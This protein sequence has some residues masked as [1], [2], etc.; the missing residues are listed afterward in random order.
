MSLRVSFTGADCIDPA[1]AVHHKPSPVSSLELIPFA[2][3]GVESFNLE[4]DLS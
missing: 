3:L 2:G 1:I 4:M